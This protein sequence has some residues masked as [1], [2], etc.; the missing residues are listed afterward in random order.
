MDNIVVRV[1]AGTSRPNRDPV[2]LAHLFQEKLE[3]IDPGFGI[4]V[5]ALAA[6]ET[7]ALTVRQVGLDGGVDNTN[8]ENTAKLVDRLGGRL[9][10]GRITRLTLPQATY[11]SRQARK[12]LRLGLQK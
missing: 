12:Y 7:N 5:V 1:Q 9:G 11:R 3:K 6:V 10:V 8:R 4:D 2:H